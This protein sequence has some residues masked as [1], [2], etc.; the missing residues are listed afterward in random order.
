MCLLMMLFVEEEIHIHFNRYTIG[1]IKDTIMKFSTKQKGFL[2]S[3]INCYVCDKENIKFMSD[4]VWEH[5]VSN[6]MA[7]DNILHSIF[8]NTYLKNGTVAKSVFLSKIPQ[9][10]RKAMNKYKLK[11]ER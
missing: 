5:I 10:A 3:I 2:Y 7:I 9:E 8:T 1:H 4:D 6:D 11:G